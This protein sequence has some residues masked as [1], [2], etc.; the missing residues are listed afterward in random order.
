MKFVINGLGLSSGGGRTVGLNVISSLST[1][2]TENEYLLIFPPNAGY[3]DISLAK[4]CGMV[5]IDPGKFKRLKRLHID[6][7]R[8]PRICRDF[9]ADVLFSMSNFGPYKVQCPQVLGIQSAYLIYPE[10]LAWAH[11]P[12]PERWA[13]RAQSP[14]FRWVSRHVARFC[15]LTEVSAKRLSRLYGISDSAI[16][17]VPNAVSDK[18]FAAMTRSPDIENQLAAYGDCLKLCYVAPFY[19]HKNHQILIA[20]MRTLRHEFGVHDVVILTTVDGRASPMARD[21]LST[22]KR[23]GFGNC[24][25]NLGHLP[26]AKV[27]SVYLS[28]DALLMPTLLETYGIPYIEAMHFG[29]PILTSDMDFAHAVCGDAALYFNPLDAADIARAIVALRQNPTLRSDLAERSRKRLSAISISWE[30]VTRR[31]VAVLHEAAGANWKRSHER[32][33]E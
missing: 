28:S 13:V 12:Y 16:R 18:I 17:V 19:P 21:F 31:Y 5:F 2:D 8:L 23:Q 32:N 33:R 14:Y 11:I 4:N 22:I 24:I 6:H 9:K 27:P 20:A 15:V 7:V 29:L 25:I 1:V 30:E 10:S 3:E 26:L